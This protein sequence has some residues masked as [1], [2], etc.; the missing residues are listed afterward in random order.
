MRVPVIANAVGRQLA[1]QPTG[2]VQ[3]NRNQQR[4]RTREGQNRKVEK[5]QQASS[6]RVPA[7]LCRR[8][9]GMEPTL[10]LNNKVAG[11]GLSAMACK[12]M[13]ARGGN[14][15]VMYV[16]IWEL[17]TAAWGSGVRRSAL[18]VAVL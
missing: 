10:E 4:Y 9:G 12:A 5:V 18:H 15:A 2:I 16:G 11:S 3:G 6:W 17:R 1:F 7:V 14:A 8:C 13:L